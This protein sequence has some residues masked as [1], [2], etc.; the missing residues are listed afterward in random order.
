MSP[1]AVPTPIVQQARAYVFPHRMWPIEFQS[2]GL[3]NLDG[4]K[5]AQTLN[6][7]QVPRDFGKPALLDRK[8]RLA[9][10]AWVGQDRIPPSI[11]RF[12][13]PGL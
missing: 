6:A 4:A 7:K 8:P 9:C 1:G 11:R 2:I 13:R 10:G 12:I 3:L 5:A